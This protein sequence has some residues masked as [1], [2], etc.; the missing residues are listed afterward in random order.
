MIRKYTFLF[1]KLAALS[2]VVL[3]IALALSAVSSALSADSPCP[4]FWSEQAR[5]A[6]SFSVAPS[7]PLTHVLVSFDASS[8]VSGTRSAWTYAAGGDRCKA[9]MLPKRI[10]SSSTGGPLA[11]AR[12]SKYYADRESH[13]RRQGRYTVT[14]TVQE[15]MPRG[16]QPAELLYGHDHGAGDGCKSPYGIV[17]VGA[18]ACG[19]RAC[20]DFPRVHIEGARRRGVSYHWD[21]GDGQTRDTTDPTTAHVYATAGVKIVTLTVS[22]K[23]GATSESQHTINAVSPPPVAS[24]SAPRAATRDSQRSSTLRVGIPRW[25]HRGVSLGLWRRA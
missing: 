14:L 13:V 17:L 4:G 1:L 24:F 6:A 10:R 21:F 5:P 19:D 16:H 22:D 18:G 7:A 2:G 9:G 15:L 20:R 8:S 12:R 3:A 11:M 23:D 25:Y